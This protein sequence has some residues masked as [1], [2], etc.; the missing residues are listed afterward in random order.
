MGVNIMKYAEAKQHAE[1]LNKH[2]T[3]YAEVVRILPESIDPPKQDDN[4]WDVKITYLPDFN[5]YTD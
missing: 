5:V 2:D 4:G 1:S 3:M